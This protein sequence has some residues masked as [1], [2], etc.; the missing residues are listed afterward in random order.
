LEYFRIAVSTISA[1]PIPSRFCGYAYR[2]P[3][4]TAAVVWFV[5]HFF[6]AVVGGVLATLIGE[7][8]RK[9]IA[10]HNPRRVG[11]PR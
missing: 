7:W 6:I 1:L 4:V 2:I 3:V 11:N 8:G 9:L 10:G 5:S